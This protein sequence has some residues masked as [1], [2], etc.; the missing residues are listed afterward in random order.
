MFKKILFPFFS[1]FLAYRT[2]D[3]LRLLN[4]KAPQECGTWENFLNAAFLSA[5]VTGFFA[6]FGFAYPTSKLLPKNYYR[7]QSPEF[8]QIV[9]QMLAVEGFRKLLLI[10][11]WGSSK[12]RKKYF[13]GTKAGI[14]QFIYETHQSEFGHLMAG[15][16]IATLSIPLALWGH[17]EVVLWLTIINVI[18]NFYPIILQRAHRIRIQRMVPD[19]T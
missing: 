17:W 10:F 13:N 18:G 8:L 5:F 3:L 11:F 19:V 7:I 4:F 15:I 12:N 16:A 14:S 2:Y 6:F 9:Y 1:L